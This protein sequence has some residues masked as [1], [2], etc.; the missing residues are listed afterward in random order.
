MCC[1][2]LPWNLG[3]FPKEVI[4]NKLD[5][6]ISEYE[7]NNPHLDDSDHYRHNLEQLIDL[8]KTVYPHIKVSKLDATLFEEDGNILIEVVSRPFCV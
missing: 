5:S 8:K 7:Y 3:L 6:L 2:Q 4:D 1:D